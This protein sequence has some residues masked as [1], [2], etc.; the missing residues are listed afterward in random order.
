MNSNK[1]SEQSKI[2]ADLIEMLNQMQPVPERDPNRVDRSTARYLAEIDDMVAGKLAKEPINKF[3]QLKEYFS[4]ATPKFKKAIAIGATLIVLIT[5]LFGSLGVTAVAASRSLPG[6]GLYSIKTRAEQT[7]I[8]LTRADENK[9]LLHLRYAG[10]RLEEIKGL[11]DKGRI[12][13]IAPIINQYEIHIQNALLALESV[14]VSDPQT[15]SKLSVMISESLKEYALILIRLSAS[16][17]EQDLGKVKEAIQFSEKAGGFQNE[18]EFKG[19]VEKITTENWV[20]SG[21]TL[22]VTAASEI[23]NAIKAGDWVDVKA[24]SDGEG[25]LYLSEVKP[26]LTDDDKNNDYSE[27]DSSPGNTQNYWDGYCSGD[28][29]AVTVSDLIVPQ[30][31]TC[32]L[33]GTSVQG[34][35]KVESNATLFAYAVQVDGNIQA[36]NASRVEVHPNSRVGGDIQVDTSGVVVVNTVWIG[37]NLQSVKNWGSQTFNSNGIGGDLQAFENSGGVTVQGN[38]IDGN[39]QCKENYPVPT[40][41][42]NTVDGNK[43]DQCKDL[44]GTAQSGTPTLG[45]STT[46]LPMPTIIPSLTPKPMGGEDT[47][48][49][50]YCTGSIGAVT[51]SELIVP[52]NTICT[53]NGT[54]VKGNIK[55]QSGATLYAYG[56]SVEGNIQA[57]G[58]NRVEVH[59]GSYVNG[60]IQ[61]KYSG[62]A[63]VN[64]VRMDGNLQSFEN[65]GN[66]SFTSNYIGGDLQ[67]FDNRGGVYV[68]GNTIGGN[69]QCKENYPAPTGGSNVVD[70]NM[71]DQCAGF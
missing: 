69:L 52:M 54:Y 41:G 14:S 46:A 16:L 45:P 44:D 20:I 3:D 27:D 29:G 25:V 55:V 62:V 50:G 60:D 21:H 49:D 8:I 58:A 2:E 57:E 35:I 22:T 59:P 40:G 38:D 63:V 24:Y 17:P 10:T 71:E 51:V 18:M 53:L 28:I 33:N 9:F 61:L 12:N 5:F 39:L 56:V 47:N 34:N 15:A 36:E 26:I 31:A 43:E 1:N 30:N 67:S 70:G 37:G 7:R 48:D 4:M 19:Y 13:Q 11:I 66:Q 68:Q 65:W 64:S 42:M 32:T 23:S 6:D